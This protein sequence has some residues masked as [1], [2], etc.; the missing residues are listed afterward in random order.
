MHGVAL[1]YQGMAH[2]YGYLF[3]TLWLFLF[4]VTLAT[5]LTYLI[6]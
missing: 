5:L 6:Y 2:I 3:L 4:T 1:K